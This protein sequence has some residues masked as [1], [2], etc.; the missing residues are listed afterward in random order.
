MR[1]VTFGEDGC[2]VRTGAAPQVLTALRNVVLALRRRGVQNVAAALR[3]HSWQP[4]AV[5]RF[6]GVASG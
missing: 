1:D 4:Q 3:Q 2:R 5:L 6:L